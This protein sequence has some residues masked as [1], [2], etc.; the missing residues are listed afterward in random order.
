[1]SARSTI[2]ATLISALSR[3]TART[4][5]ALTCSGVQVPRPARRLDPGVG[6]HPRLADEARRDHGDADALRVEVG[7]QGEGE[8]AQAELGRAV[9]RGSGGGCLAVRRADEDEVAGAALDHRRRERLRHQH[10]RLEVD[11]QGALQ[12]LGGEVIERPGARQARVGD[13]NVHVRRFG[14]EALRRALLGQVGRQHP[15]AVARQLGGERLER[16]ALAGAE[17]EARPPAAS[18]SGDRPAEA[19]CGPCE[20]RFSAGKFH[21]R[22]QA[23]SQAADRIRWFPNGQEWACEVRMATKCW[24]SVSKRPGDRLHCRRSR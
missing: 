11:A 7:P 6:E 5:A 17:H 16:L 10:R 21:P 9:D 1:M 23:S 4:T 12:L 3:S 14:G 24:F 2:G 18:A 19:A 13:E 22:A 20:Q 8:A 15:V